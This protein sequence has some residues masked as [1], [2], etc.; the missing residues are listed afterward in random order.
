MQLFRL[1]NDNLLKKRETRRRCLNFNM[2]L[3]IPLSPSARLVQDDPSNITLQGVYEEWC[4]KNGTQSYD[5]VLF[6]VEKMSETAQSTQMQSQQARAQGSRPTEEEKKAL[7]YFSQMRLETYLA[8]TETMVPNTVALEYFQSIYPSYA[9]FYLFRRTFSYQLASL[10]FMNFIMSMAARHPH[11]FVISRSTG[12]VQGTELHPSIGGQRPMFHIT[13]PVGFRFSPNIQM[14]LGPLATEGIFAPSL[15]VIARALTEADGKGDGDMDLVLSLFVR[16][17]VQYWITV[18]PK[19]AHV[20][21]QQQE[22]ASGIAGGGMDVLIRGS[23]QSNSD[24]VVKKALVLAKSPDAGNL[25][26]NQTI[27]DQIA[28]AVNPRNLAVCDPLWMPWL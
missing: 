25:P 26:A 11:K 7:E 22:A 12:K 20:L 21:A 5:P 13:D 8:I 16:D 27:V 10:S 9:D 6:N 15:M 19:A 14:L 24:A 3:T 23:V 17:E 4:R 1:F 28:L 18:S 2:A